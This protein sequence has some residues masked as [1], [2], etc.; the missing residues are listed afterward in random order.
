[1]TVAIQTSNSPPGHA[2]III[3]TDTHS[4]DLSKIQ[5]FKK[6]CLHALYKMRLN[7]KNRHATQLMPGLY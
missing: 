3:Y 4:P 7:L 2:G 6:K 5:T 1:M